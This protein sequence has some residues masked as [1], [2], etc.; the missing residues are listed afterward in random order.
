MTTYDVPRHP[1]TASVAAVGAR[2]HETSGTAAGARLGWLRIVVGILSR[3]VL[4]TL[5]GL[6]LWA[7]V[8]AVIGWTP[9][10]VMTGSMEP[11]IHPGDVVV[12]RPVAE[13]SIHRGQVLLFQDPDRAD[14]LRLHRYDDNGQGTQIV[15][16]G[17]ANQAADST[18]IDRSA[19]VGVGYL[20][21]PYIGTPFVWAAGHQ[22]G[23]LLV[24]G[25]ALMLLVLGAQADRS[26]RRELKGEGRSEGGAASAPEDATGTSSATGTSGASVS[27]T[28]TL[29]VST[30]LVLAS[31]AASAVA[32]DPASRRSRR[33][34]DRRERRLRRLR[35]A[36][37]TLAVVGLV[38]GLA[39]TLVVSGGA[40]AAFSSQA[41]N[42]TSNFA[43]ASAYECLM[44]AVTDSPVFSYGYNEAS[45]TAAL[46]S[47]STGR[48]GTLSAGVTRVSGACGSSP[49]VTLNGTSGAVTTNAPAVTAPTAFTVESWINLPANSAG[50]KIIGFG[51]QATGASGQY[52]RQLWVSG[53]GVITFGTY[54]GGTKTVSTTKTYRDG[55]WHHVAGTVTS[56][57]VLTLYVD[58][59]VVGTPVQNALGEPNTGYWR[60]GYDNL[61]GWPNIPASSANYFFGGSLDDTAAY[62]TALPAATI[63]Q[64]VKNGR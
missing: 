21:V 33:L 4:G 64:H 42:K 60:V 22:W 26:L 63:A 23:H 37:G 19:V 3:T 14:H 59:V 38:G 56:A 13:S 39:L 20:R 11:R 57:G 45:G 40:G 61:A 17:D 32:A 58:G 41:A 48:A 6:L 8:P 44:P 27:G 55:A 34:A 10:T 16:K 18:P 1:A 36:A 35:G 24:T 54:N 43:A 52:D 50:G 30:G 53:T 49:Y 29:P 46:D 5:V 51:N 12:A 28:S 15:T 25:S 7:A 31:V 47:S 62:N 9:T 2:G